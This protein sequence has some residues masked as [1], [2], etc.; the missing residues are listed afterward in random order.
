MDNVTPMDGTDGSQ[1]TELTVPELRDFV[2][3]NRWTYAKTMP[4]HPHEYVLL[5]NSSS[6][7]GFFRFVMTIR[8]YG[9]D[10]YFYTKRIRYLDVDGRRYWTMGDL[11]ETTWV[12]NRAL[13]TGP[14][15]PMVL[16]K[17]PFITNP[18]NGGEHAGTSI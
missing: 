10:E 11:L 16:N 12:L 1:W 2:E 3:R 8:R 9:Y 6:E 17:T 5:K 18:P 13:N 7:D 15:V 4:K 14:D